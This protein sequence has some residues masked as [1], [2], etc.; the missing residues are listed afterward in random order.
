MQGE[1]G[2][3]ISRREDWQNPCRSLRVEVLTK[4][5]LTLVCRLQLREFGVAPTILCY[6]YSKALHNHNRSSTSGGNRNEALVSDLLCDNSNPVL[7]F[8]NSR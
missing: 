2:V 3:V 6:C 4:P 8:P 7:Q 5:R 1:G